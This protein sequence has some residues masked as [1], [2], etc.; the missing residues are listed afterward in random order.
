MLTT[1]VTIDKLFNQMWNQQQF[2]LAD[3]LFS[4]QFTVYYSQGSVSSHADFK[5]ML[6]DWFIGFPDLHHTIDDCI[7]QENHIAIRWYGKGTHLGEFNGIAATGENFHYEGITIA[8]LDNSNRIH[9]AWVATNLTESLA[10]L[11]S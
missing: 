9:T 3:N 5:A 4:P 2:D 10:K 11:Q 8:H 7:E 1:N 6:R